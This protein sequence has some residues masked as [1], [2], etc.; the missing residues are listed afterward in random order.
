MLF[1]PKIKDSNFSSQ[2][3]NE[4]SEKLSDLRSETSKWPDS[5]IF[6]GDI[7][8]ELFE[9]I[10]N[11]GW[12]LLAF[13]PKWVTGP[14]KIIFEYSKPLTQIEDKGTIFDSS[15]SE[16]KINGIPGPETMAKIISKYVAPSFTIE[17]TI[18]PSRQIKL[19]RK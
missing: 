11:N 18:R 4:L 12:D 13:N 9:Y 2:L 1:V 16:R 17:R 14:N 6:S 5:L 19:V 3:F 15:F 10:Q 7:G 8:K